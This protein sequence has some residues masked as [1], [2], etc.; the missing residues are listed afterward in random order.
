MRMRFQTLA[1]GSKG[2]ATLIACDDG[3]R[4]RYLL[5]DCGLPQ[6]RLHRQLQAAGIEAQQLDAI[7]IS[8]E[9]D[10]HIGCAHALAMRYQIPIYMSCGTYSALRNG[11]DIDFG[12]LLHLV[13]DGDILDLAGMQVQPFTIPHD[14]REP[15][16][17]RCSNGART[18]AIATDVGHASSHVLQHLHHCHAIVLEANH[19][20]EL[21]A[22]SHYPNFLKQRIAGQYGHLNNAQAADVL[23]HIAHPQ[24]GCVVA[25]HLSES[26]NRPELAQAALA[27]A[28]GRNTDEIIAAP[29]THSS[30]WL[31]V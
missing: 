2:N 3:V 22:Q 4:S 27:Q 24:L 11:C 30:A 19:D 21:L 14:A 28:L 9:H 6:R 7:F 20:S 5:L 8:H 31:A 25:A 26:N 1:S 10:D 29:A 18:L 12:K 15:L 13:R 16:Q 17:L 23:A